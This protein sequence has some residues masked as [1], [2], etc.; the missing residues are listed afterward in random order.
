LPYKI[1]NPDFIT[2]K[3][4]FHLR[5]PSF[6][7]GLNSNL[8]DSIRIFL[9]EKPLARKL[10]KCYDS[11]QFGKFG[12]FINLGR[13]KTLKLKVFIILILGF[14]IS[15]CNYK[16]REPVKT[17]GNASTASANN[18][19]DYTSADTAKSGNTISGADETIDGKLV[20]SSTGASATYPCKGREVE[21]GE[22]ATANTLT[23]TGEC[24]KL[25]VDGVS[26]S[27]FVEKVGEIVVTGTSNKV[28]YG[29]G[30]GGK[31]P[32]ISKSGTS[33][34]VESKKAAEEKKQANK[35]T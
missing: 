16:L 25:I 23:L 14:V 1:S 29:E 17:S 19:E 22:D 11:G 8:N 12:I 13:I 2:I 30:I 20:L 24:K 15:G 6:G 7:K 27:V 35:Q 10:N 28:I 5:C 4:Y 34:S 32:K 3:Q 9:K 18:K 31:Q 33:T 21:I 26:N